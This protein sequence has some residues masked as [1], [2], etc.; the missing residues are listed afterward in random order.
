MPWCPKCR[1]EYR[2]GFTVCADCG[3]T[4]VDVLGE[5]EKVKSAIYTSTKEEIDHIYEFLTTSNV[6]GVSTVDAG[7]GMVSLM[8]EEEHRKEINFALNTYF[9]QRKEEAEEYFEKQ[10]K[11][12]KEAFDGDEEEDDEEGEESD[13]SEDT[14]KSK[15]IFKVVKDDEEDEEADGPAEESD[16]DEDDDEEDEEDSRPAKSTSSKNEK[17]FRSSKEKADDALTSAFSLC[18]IGVLGLC[19]EALVVFH[20]IPLSIN[21][22]PGYVLYGFMA[23]VFLFLCISGISSFFTAKRLRAT[24]VDETS[25]KDEILK[26][27]KEEAVDTV[28]KLV[29]DN[30]D[31][32][33]ETIYFA[34]MEFLKRA[35]KSEP[36]FKDIDNVTL[37]GLLDENYHDLFPDD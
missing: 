15:E 9:E 37:D 33:D 21:G 13:E 30:D 11:K 35:V 7:E 31:K 36:K 8:A 29:K 10:R 25:T 14:S 18:I 24:I 34:R 23:C 4:L 16:E 22:T 27:L 3:A 20:V 19:F 1:N 5:E 32:N 12:I 28:N 2:E 6:R 17:S 26:F